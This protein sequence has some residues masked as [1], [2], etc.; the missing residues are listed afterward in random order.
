M[1]LDP[2]QGL[3]LERRVEEREPIIGNTVITGPFGNGSRDGF[4]GI[5]ANVSSSGACVYTCREVETGLAVTICSQVFG[6]SPKNASIRWC[7][8][9]T[10]EVF[11]LGLSFY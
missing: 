2:V 10:Q 9:V 11:S 4:E 5:T 3:R 1:T 8:K 7:R 6:T